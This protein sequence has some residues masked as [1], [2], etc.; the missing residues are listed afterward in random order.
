MDHRRWWLAGVLA[1]VATASRPNGAIAMVAIV[2]VALGIRAG[3]R[4][5]AALVLPSVAFLVGWMIYLDVTTGD[6]VLF[7]TAKAGWIE[8]TLFEFLADPLH[9]RLAFTHIVLLLIFLVPYAM[10]FRRQ[11]PAWAAVVVLGVLPA[12][13][14]GSG[15]RGPVRRAGVPDP[16]RVRRRTLRPTALGD[17]RPF[18]PS[19]P[20]SS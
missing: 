11:P 2:V 7:W 16:D 18:W 10:R 3:W 20:S 6:P 5:L 13:A 8:M 15:G 12:L 14:L 4:Q 1:A 17:R 19:L 9:Q